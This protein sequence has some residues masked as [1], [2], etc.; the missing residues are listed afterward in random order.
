MNRVVDLSTQEELF[1]V[2]LTTTTTTILVGRYHSSF[3]AKLSIEIRSVALFKRSTLEN[4]AA[5]RG[6]KVIHIRERQTD[7]AKPS[8][9]QRGS[10]WRN[11]THLIYQATVS[12]MDDKIAKL[13]V[14]TEKAQAEM[15]QD[16]A[17]LDDAVK[18]LTAAK[19]LLREM[20]AEDQAIFQVNDTK[21]PELI[22]LHQLAKE[23]YETSQ[24][25][26]ETNHRYL[27]M[28][29]EKAGGTKTK[30]AAES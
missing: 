22:S 21:L 12:T 3:A 6:Q 8:K 25:R 15:E 18:R 9:E 29:K 23:K 19:D 27:T 16:K 13:Q 17:A 28:M 7:H 5:K 24:T 1:T 4:H 14:A 11:K 10:A 30:T 2:T 20:D 26:Y